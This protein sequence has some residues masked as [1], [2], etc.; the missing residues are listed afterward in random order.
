MR[1]H[2][3]K[4]RFKPQSW[5]AIPQKELPGG[6]LVNEFQFDARLIDIKPQQFADP[7]PD[8]ADTG[9]NTVAMATQTP[10]EQQVLQAVPT[11]EDVL[12]TATNWG[13]TDPTSVEY[14]GDDSAPMGNDPMLFSYE[15]SFEDFF[16]EWAAE[17][18]GIFDL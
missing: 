10:P 5:G 18:P 9:I 13:P 7:L 15:P 6:V 3:N 16:G 12:P 2:E 14:S 17:F 1:R 8:A 4:C 11:P